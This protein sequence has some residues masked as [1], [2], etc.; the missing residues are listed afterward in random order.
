MVDCC[1]HCNRQAVAK[2][3]SRVWVAASEDNATV[4]VALFNLQEQPQTVSATFEELAIAWKHVA[5]SDVWRNES[6]GPPVTRGVI[7]ATVGRHGAQLLAVRALKHDDDDGA[8]AGDDG[9]GEH[10]DARVAAKTGRS[11]IRFAAPLFGDGMI[12]QRDA[13][14]KIW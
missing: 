7:S 10:D 3:G 6:I 8:D 2:S 4:Y 14:A 11:H 12:L 9:D 13:A 5:V 1:S